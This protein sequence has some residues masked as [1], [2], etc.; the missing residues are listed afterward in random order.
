MTWWNLTQSDET[1]IHM[2]QAWYK[3]TYIIR[4]PSVLFGRCRIMYRV[5]ILNSANN[6]I[7]LDRQRNQKVLLNQVYQKFSVYLGYILTIA[8]SQTLIGQYA[9][10]R[11]VSSVKYRLRGAFKKINQIKRNLWL[12]KGHIRLL[13]HKLGR[14]KKN[15]D[16]TLVLG[17]W[18]AFFTYSKSKKVSL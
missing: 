7:T 1:R 14:N 4:Q 11:E 12:D 18:S 3:D 13:E 10:I 16:F 2:T 15:N 17:G 5:K 9:I 6:D 8:G